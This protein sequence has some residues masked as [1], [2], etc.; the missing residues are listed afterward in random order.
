MTANDEKEREIPGTDIED[1]GYYEEEER[2]KIS[3]PL[4]VFPSYRYAL[5]ALAFFLACFVATIFFPDRSLREMLWASGRT[6]FVE[7]QYW[8]LVTTI[9]LHADMHHLLSNTPL[10]LV[11][12]WFLRAFFGLKLFPLAALV[13]GILSI[14]I[15]LI[16]YMPDMKLVGASGM[17]YGMAALWLVFY[18]RYE[19]DHSPG[20][21]VFRAAGFSL[22]L[23]FPTTFQVQVS[24]IAHAA[25]FFSGL[26]IALAL[27]PLVE[28]NKNVGKK[29]KNEN[30]NY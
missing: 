3:G 9:F 21:R 26:L 19:T 4:S 15:S 30:N 14:G 27:I 29:N 22:A 20:K 1:G 13:T 5:P 2:E 10:L 18:I 16:F 25:G 6:V 11:F 23:L 24:Y 28:I 7:H 12:G 17:V 8:R